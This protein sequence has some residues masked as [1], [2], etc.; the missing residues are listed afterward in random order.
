MIAVPQ[1]RQL[2]RLCR[3][4]GRH[5]KL[6]AIK[7]EASA[8]AKTQYATDRL[9]PN[10]SRQVVDRIRRVKLVFLVFPVQV[11][12]NGCRKRIAGLRSNAP[13]HAAGG[14]K[15]ILCRKGGGFE[16]LQGARVADEVW[17]TAGAQQPLELRRRP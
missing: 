5:S 11:S 7:R 14:R 13:Q 4:V 3:E 16:Y 10:R 6:Q 17:L 2:E 15:V 8:N 1:A 9:P 12:Q